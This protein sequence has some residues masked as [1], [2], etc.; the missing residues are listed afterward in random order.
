MMVYFNIEEFNCPCCNQVKMHGQFLA[1]LDRARHIAKIPFYINSGYRCIK[2]NKEVGGTK[3]SSHMIGWA[4]DIKALDNYTRFKIIKALLE[5]G[6]KRI[7]IY[8]TFIHVD[9]DPNKSQNIL[10]I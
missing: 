5:V 7:K 6:F 10:M 8:K 3:E 2:H 9:L 4:A 1:K